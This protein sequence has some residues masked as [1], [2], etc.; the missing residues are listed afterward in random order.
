M[1]V[2]KEQYVTK[3]DILNSYEFKIVKKILREKFPW[4]I[5]VVLPNKSD[6]ELNKYEAILVRIIMNPYLFAE[7]NNTNI[8]PFALYNLMTEDYVAW[9]LSMPFDMSFDEAR[10]IEN[11]IND[12][13]LAIRKSPVFPDEL[14]LK[15][16][17]RIYGVGDFKF[18]SVEK[19]PPPEK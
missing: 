5:D 14:K 15:F 7:M 17:N 2:P 1:R 10:A 16:K 8:S 4:I 19:L 9:M 13:M 18:P 6:V 3:E 12:V 11:N